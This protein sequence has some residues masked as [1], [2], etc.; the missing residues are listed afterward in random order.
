MLDFADVFD[1]NTVSSYM[2]YPQPSLP[3]L[4][5]LLL[6]LCFSPPPFPSSPSLQV[7]GLGG[8]GP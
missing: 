1:A 2:Y 6:F 7:Q 8:A 5:L 3:P 4:S